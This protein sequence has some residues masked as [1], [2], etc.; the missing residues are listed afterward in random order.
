[1]FQCNRLD[2]TFSNNVTNAKKCGNA[3][4]HEKKVYE[5]KVYEKKVIFQFGGLSPP[6]PPVATGLAVCET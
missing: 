5:K 6:N 2:P 3:F 4:P 1:M